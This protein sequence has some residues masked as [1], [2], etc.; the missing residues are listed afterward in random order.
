MSLIFSEDCPC[1]SWEDVSRYNA[2]FG[3]K[4]ATSLAI[5]RFW[6][7]PFVIVSVSHAREL[8]DGS[9]GA[10][11]SFFLRVQR[12][13]GQSNEIIVRSSVVGESIWDRGTY[14]SEVV[15]CTDKEFS[16]SLATAAQRVITS[17]KGKAIGLMVQRFVRPTVQGNFGNL[18]RISKTRDHWEISTSESDGSTKLTRLNSQRD[19]AYSPSDILAVKA[20]LSVERFFG[21]VAAYLNN[22]LLLGNPLR[23]NCEWITDNQNYYIVQIDQE[24]EDFVGKNPF[25]VRITPTK[26]PEGQQGEFFQVADEMALKSWD[27]LKVLSDLWEPSAAH[28]PT[29]F[30]A[31]LDRIWKSNHVDVLDRLEED[32]AKLIGKAGIIVRTSVAA[33][34]EKIVNLPRTECLTARQAAEW[35]WRECQSLCGADMVPNL[36]FV[37]HRFIASRASAWVRADP[38]APTVEIHA[39][40]GLPDALQYFPF[41][42]WDVHIPTGVATES[43]A[44]KPNMLLSKSDG[45]WEYVRIKNDLAR[46]N[47]ITSSEAK[48]LATRSMEIALRLGRPCHIMWFIGCL[49]ENEQGY[50]IPWYWT[51]AH[52][53]ERNVERSSYE[54]FKVTSIENLYQN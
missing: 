11:S 6:T 45:S 21:K 39:N 41:D 38:K 3:M 31:Q 37:A 29:L 50:S 48:E 34:C 8:A 52:D 49:T 24:D 13:A 22:E 32:F 5:P 25:Q 43:P 30:F 54:I 20:G 19:S 40:W 15:D 4:A 12:L 18:Q 17:A 2:E 14:E 16:E 33:G 9:L 35:C 51:E 47:S 1:I 23:L 26:Q 28:K 44:Y 46:R 36:A 27:K 7:P 42:I 10:Q 53:S